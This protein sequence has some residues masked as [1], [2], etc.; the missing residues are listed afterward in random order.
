M[1]L[2]GRGVALPDHDKS[3][4]GARGHVDSIGAPD[5]TRNR[6][7]VTYVPA[8]R[9]P[10]RGGARGELAAR[11]PKMAVLAGALLAGGSA[12][13]TA[14]ADGFRPETFPLE[15]PAV[16]IE[17]T[18]PEP[19]PFLALA[20][21]APAPAAA[22]EA[23]L[24]VAKPA[25]AV[26]RPEP[27]PP[28]PLSAPRRDLAGFLAE[29]GHVLAPLPDAPAAPALT[30]D[31][32]AAPEM[33]GG[34]ASAPVAPASIAGAETPQPDPQSAVAQTFPTL[35]VN[36]TELGAVTMRGDTVHLAALLGLLQL[37]MPA[38]EFARLKASPAAESFVSLAMLR[39]AGL[40][41]TVD[42]QRERLTLAA[43]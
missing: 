29:Q 4:T 20:T 31:A 10:G 16:P 39:E 18:G 17:P 28:E 13:S 42:P 24:A 27:A 30:S 40:A 26:A 12:H 19:L 5:L 8:A 38:E 11:S 23:P 22:V 32:Q 25:A 2:T 6:V 15:T 21:V 33:E 43:L 36:G 3:V 1:T 34:A 37:R 41:V 7:F 9:L 14:D 35:S